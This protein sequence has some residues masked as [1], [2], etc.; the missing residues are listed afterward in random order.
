MPH[1]VKSGSAERDR[2]RTEG[3]PAP[4]L[5]PGSTSARDS[6]GYILFLLEY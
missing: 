2:E 1:L 6:P 5:A 3:G 4:Y